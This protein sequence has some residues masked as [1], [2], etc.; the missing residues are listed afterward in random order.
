MKTEDDLRTTPLADV[1]GFRTATRPERLTRRPGRSTS[2]RL[3]APSTAS[4][5][6]RALLDDC[7]ILRS[8]RAI[9][10]APPRDGRRVPVP[11]HD[12]S[13]TFVPKTL[14]SIIEEQARWTEDDL[15]RPK[16]LG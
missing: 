9:I 15:K 13:G 14:R 16:L 6:S 3:R 10:A 5:V 11:F 4:E 2:R 8:R 7:F 12:S 1:R